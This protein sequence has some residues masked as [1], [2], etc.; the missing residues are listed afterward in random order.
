MPESALPPPLEDSGAHLRAVQRIA[1]VG[2]WEFQ[3]CD[4]ALYCSE[5]ACLIF[6]VAPEHMQAGPRAWL[7]RIP[8]DDLPAVRMAFRRALRGGSPLEVEHRIARAD[9]CVRNVMQ[10][11]ELDVNHIGNRMLVG[12]MQD[13]TDRKQSDRAAQRFAS[14][15]ATLDKITDAFVT[16][17]RKLCFSYLNAQAERV[18]KSTPGELLG[19][20]VW[21]VFPGGPGSIY[22]EKFHEAATDGR[23]VL[24]EAPYAPLQSWLEV[25]AYPSDDGLA[26]HFRDIAKRRRAEESAHQS[27]ERFLI[28]AKATADTVWDW[29]LVSDTLWWNESIQTVFG[30]DRATLDPSP[31]SWTSRIHPEEMQ[32]VVDGIHGVI[33][34]DRENWSDEYR[35][36]RSDG[37]W[38][39]VLDRGFVIRNAEGEAVRMVGSMTDLTQQKQSAIELARLN[40]ALRLRSACDEA[41]NRATSESELLAAICGLALDIGGYRLAWVGYAQD[42]PKRSIQ[43]MAQAGDAADVEYVDALALSW[44]ESAPEGRGAGP[45]GV[46]VRSGVATFCEDITKIPYFQPWIATAEKRGLRGLIILPLRNR[47][48]VFGLMTLYARDLLVTSGDETKLLQEMADNVAFGLENLRAREE[49][50]QIQTAVLR[51]AASV[52]AATGAE[53]FE[54]LAVNMAEAVG[55]DV[56][57]VAR[58]LAQDVP[59]AR[60]ISAVV[61][62]VVVDDFCYLLAGTPCE[63]LLA[64]PEAVVLE[65]LSS[66]P[67]KAFEGM[68]AFVGRRLDNSA[69]RPVGLLCVM[70]REPPRQAELITTTLQIFA[71]RAAAELERQES[72]ARIREQAALIDKA[73]DAIVVR[74]L[75][76]RVRFWNKGAERLYGWK[77]EEAIGRPI[78]ELLAGDPDDMRRAMTIVLRDGMWSGEIVE[79]RK[80]GSELVIEDQWTLVSDENG[81]PESIFAIKTDITQRKAAESEIQNLAFYDALTQLPN[82]RLLLDRL[83]GAIRRNALS[84]QE[85]AL[86]FVDLDN[87]KALNDT[88]GHDRGD[89]LL[90]EVAARLRTCVRDSDT[91]AR[92]GGDEFVLMIESLSRHTREAAAQATRVGEKVLAALNEPF[93]IADSE[94]YSTPSIGVT[95]FGSQQDSAAELLKRADLAMYQAKAAGRNTMRFFDPAMQTM[96]ARRVAMESE[97]RHALQHHDFILHYQPQI[98]REGRVSGAEALVRWQH[99]ER[100][101]VSPAEFISLAEDTGLIVPLGK[102]VLQAACAQLAAWSALAVTE[103]L[104]LAVNVSARQFRHPEFVEQVIEILQTSGARPRR[105]KLELTESLLVENVEETVLRMNTLKRHGVGFSLDD[106]GTGY[107]SLAY[108]KRLPLDQLKIDKS[109]VRDVLVD[110]NDAAIARTIVALARSLGLDVIAEG[111][112]TE[113]QRLFLATHGCYDYQGFLASRPVPIAQFNDFVHSVG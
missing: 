61:A 55:A 44:D 1:Q 6:G 94:R 103:G 30:F 66:M 91:V 105:L 41:L 110:P 100:G 11:F 14:R 39:W 58:I 13:I 5:Q 111:V 79:R 3:L 70:F 48:R 60:T 33:D 69:G 74:G 72:D 95:L 77:A 25:R 12:A 16:L 7:A 50:R 28:V 42:D 2:S 96:V 107:S 8:S 99:A 38:A 9:G 90:R 76:N 88:L 23:Q 21:Q 17:D 53:F 67:G 22:T 4:R 43:I 27:Q 46:T 24:F 40:R 35:F 113:E 18:L 109:F 32:R 19:T 85:G 29:D 104:T 10:R 71:S 64:A 34:S 45:A 82:R 112:E 52:T 15:M 75:D 78:E 73:K 89:E 84:H 65:G 92:L 59:A 57:I 102:W 86:L 101:L 83:Q 108:L 98:N 51:V 68:R 106:F 81:N 63:A 93:L 36:A 31:G 47:Q 80:D 87:F 97:L 54:Q 37:S 56:A 62:G 26:I 20:S 49:R